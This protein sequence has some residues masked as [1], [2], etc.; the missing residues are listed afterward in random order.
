LALS[1]LF[2]AIHYSD[3]T[4]F[5]LMKRLRVFSLHVWKMA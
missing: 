5:H 3:A 2:A 4:D 1:T